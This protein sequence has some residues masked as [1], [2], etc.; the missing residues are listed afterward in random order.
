MWCNIRC[1]A[2]LKYISLCWI[3][4]VENMSSED[5]RYVHWWLQI[6]GMITLNTIIFNNSHYNFDNI[7]MKWLHVIRHLHSFF[8][9][10]ISAKK[11][12]EFVFKYNFLLH[13]IH[14]Y[15]INS[16]QQMNNFDN[17]LRCKIKFRDLKLTH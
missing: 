10:F 16:I 12:R 7:L 3:E 5:I 15:N 6:C 13:D 8:T 4:Y 1:T 2:N 14:V 9:S 17:L 11:I